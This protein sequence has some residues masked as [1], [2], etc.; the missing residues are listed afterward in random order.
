MILWPGRVRW[1]AAP[2]T[3]IV[4]RARLAVDHV[5]DEAGAVVDVPDVDLL[6]GDQVGA[7]HQLGVDR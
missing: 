6:V 5:G 7:R 1:A 4:A 3:C 2:L